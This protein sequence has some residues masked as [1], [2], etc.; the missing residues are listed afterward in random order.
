MLS[1]RAAHSAT[2]AH[3]VAPEGAAELARERRGVNRTHRVDAPELGCAASGRVRA[4]VV[5]GAV[6]DP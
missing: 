4:G 5:P 3:I 2:C 1:E 6:R